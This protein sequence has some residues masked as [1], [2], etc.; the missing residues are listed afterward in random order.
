MT[1]VTKLYVVMC[2]WIQFRYGRFVKSNDL[3]V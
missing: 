3:N 1:L 2:D